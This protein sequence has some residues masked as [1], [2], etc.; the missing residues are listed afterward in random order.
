[1]STELE[2]ELTFLA[3]DLPPEI[4][5][6]KPQILKDVYV[7]RSNGLWI[8]R[9]RKRDNYFELTKKLKLSPTDHSLHEETNIEITEDEYNILAPCSELVI[10]KKRYKVDIEG[11][12]AEVDV[13]GGR[14]KGL[15]LI[16][17]EFP[18]VTDRDAFSAPKYCLYDATQDKEISA[19][20]LVGKSYS[21][22]EE[23]LTTKGYKNL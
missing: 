5:G 3:S 6:G 19:G 8:L 18:S 12:S 20:V 14:L 13:F 7:N 4:S 2:V 21:D 11:R 1:M 16:D 22:M 17:F 10:E 15:V 23:W 9:L